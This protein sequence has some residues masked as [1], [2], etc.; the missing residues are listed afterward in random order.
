MYKDTLIY[1]TRNRID[2]NAQCNDDENKMRVR[3]RERG[4]KRQEKVLR[5]RDLTKAV[6]KEQINLGDAE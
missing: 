5:M 2:N 3:E 6:S 4:V 1:L